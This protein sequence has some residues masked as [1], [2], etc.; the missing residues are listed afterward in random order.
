M[1][2]LDDDYGAPVVHIK[3]KGGLIKCI[4]KE[5]W[6]CVGVKGW[7]PVVIYVS[8]STSSGYEV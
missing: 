7:E 4:S 6:L 5:N 8:L 1:M 3:G 2:T